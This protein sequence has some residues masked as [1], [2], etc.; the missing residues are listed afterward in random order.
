MN[1]SSTPQAARVDPYHGELRATTATGAEMVDAASRFALEFADGAQAHD[2]DATFAYEHL[3]KLRAD[4]YL[5][6]PIP[7]EL[8]GG[9]VLSLHDVLV[10]SSRLARG[11]AATAI[12]VNMHLAGVANAVESWRRAT[13]RGQAAR[14]AALAAG[15]R[16]VVGREDVFA[17]AISEPS[18]QDLT[19]PATTARRV[20]EGWVVNGRKAFATMGPAATMLNVAVTFHNDAGHER[21]GFA[22]IAPDAPGVVFHDDWDAM[23]MRASASGSISFESVPLPAGAVHDV[24]P[25]G[26]WSAAMLDRYLSS[27]AFHASASLGIAEAAHAAVIT[28]RANRTDATLADPQAVTDL[29]ANV[30][31]IAAMRASLDRVGHLLD[32]FVEAHLDEDPTL[33]AVQATFAEVQ[34]SKA[35]LTTAAVRVVDRALALSGGAGYLARHPLAKAWRDARAGGFMHPLGANQAGAFLA[36]TALGAAPERVG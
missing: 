17:A 35:F 11:D 29:A 8:G 6:A 27:G 4:G 28:S 13:V 3:D 25:A 14:A 21:Y 34:A 31:D 24:F 5:Y 1:A 30:V 9:G 2:R 20:D 16:A 18:P 19:R 12:G 32:E 36:R 23:G 10:A 7:C 33:A 22:L 15:L 26:V